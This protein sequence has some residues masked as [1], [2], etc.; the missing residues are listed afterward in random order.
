MYSHLLGILTSSLHLIM[1]HAL[2]TAEKNRLPKFF[3]TFI[4]ILNILKGASEKHC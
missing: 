4:P 1:Y 3:E 2:D